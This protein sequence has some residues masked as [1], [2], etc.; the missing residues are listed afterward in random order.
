MQEIGFHVNI[1]KFHQISYIYIYIILYIIPSLL[2]ADAGRMVFDSRTEGFPLTCYFI[3]GCD[4]TAGPRS[5]V[6]VPGTGSRVLGPKN[7]INV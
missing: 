2:S 7:H 5:R 6:P 4:G 1:H 3:P